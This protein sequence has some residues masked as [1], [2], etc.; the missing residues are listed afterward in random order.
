MTDVRFLE[1]LKARWFIDSFEC[2][3]KHHILTTLNFLIEKNPSQEMAW[4]AIKKFLEAPILI[5]SDEDNE[6]ANKTGYVNKENRNRI[7]NLLYAEDQ[8]LFDAYQT[9]KMRKNFILPVLSLLSK[10]IKDDKLKKRYDELVFQF[11]GVHG[12][13][14]PRAYEYEM[15][16]SRKRGFVICLISLVEKV[17]EDSVAVSV[18]H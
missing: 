6:E 15:T 8:N 16:N 2:Y 13:I 10:V 7:K 1:D 18:S 11:S 9:N 12:Q 17:V 3:E 5:D 4:G 14:S